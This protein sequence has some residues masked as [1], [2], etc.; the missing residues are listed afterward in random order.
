[1]RAAIAAVRERGAGR[2]VVAVPVAPARTIRE[3]SDEADEV[4]CPVSPEPFLAV[5]RFY[6]DF[7]QTTDDEVVDLLRRARAGFRDPALT[8]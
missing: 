7:E 8:P 5:G 4:V 1:M 6:G 3:L 2:V